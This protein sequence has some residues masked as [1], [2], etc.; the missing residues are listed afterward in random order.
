MFDGNGGSGCVF[1]VSRRVNS[2]VWPLEGVEGSRTAAGGFWSA[3]STRGVFLEV[4]RMVYQRSQRR[5]SVFSIS[6][7]AFQF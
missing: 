6:L 2:F 7:L 4:Q 1:I 3:G 5:T